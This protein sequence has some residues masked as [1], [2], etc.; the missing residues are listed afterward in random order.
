[1]IYMFENDRMP[2]VHLSLNDRMPDET[3]MPERSGG[4]CAGVIGG[5]LAQEGGSTRRV[6]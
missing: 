3:F 5:G 2:A 6:E 1:M 4:L